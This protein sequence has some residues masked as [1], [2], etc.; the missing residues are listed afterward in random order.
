MVIF[1]I[2]SIGC[3]AILTHI[4]KQIS[5]F[6]LNQLESLARPATD[7]SQS[8]SPGIFTLEGIGD[9]IKCVLSPN[10]QQEDLA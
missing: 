4:H 3:C 2:I 1:N 9:W 10:I 7:M 8:S 6:V 5:Q